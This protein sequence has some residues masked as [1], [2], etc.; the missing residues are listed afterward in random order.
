ML[1]NDD[2]FRVNPKFLYTHVDH[3]DN[4]SNV[5]GQLE[6]SVDEVMQILKANNVLSKE[7]LEI[8]EKRNEN[9]HAYKS[10]DNIGIRLQT[11]IVTYDRWMYLKQNGK[12][13]SDYFDKNNYG[14]I[15]IYGMGQLGNRLFEELDHTMIHVLFAIDRNADR[16]EC[17]I[18]IFNIDSIEFE[19]L[20]NNVDAIVVTAVKSFN[21]IKS[22]LQKKYSKPI[23]SLVD[24]LV[25][26]VNEQ[27]EE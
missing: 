1:S 15:A 9:K 6:N 26:M 20:K 8:I 22:E 2:R 3:G 10:V 4:T 17:G 14:S 19:K 16:M 7:Q 24:I 11:I 12:N 5:I 23:L 18:P 13:L 25:E 27:L 21:S